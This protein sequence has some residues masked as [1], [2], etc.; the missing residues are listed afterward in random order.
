MGPALTIQMKNKTHMYT[1][2]AKFVREHIVKLSSTVRINYITFT[3]HTCRRF[4]PP[5]EFYLLSCERIEQILEFFHF[6][7][8]LKMLKK[9]LEWAR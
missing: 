7:L 4:T 3:I 1:S 5:V 8:P 9:A 6:K 2:R